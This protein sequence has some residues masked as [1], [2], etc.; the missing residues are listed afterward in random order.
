MGARGLRRLG[1]VVWGR[2]TGRG[3][4]RG[5]APGD[6]PFAQVRVEHAR[7][8]HFG[9]FR[10]VHKVGVEYAR[11]S[12]RLIAG[13]PPR[14]RRWA[15]PRALRIFITIGCPKAMRTGLAAVQPANLARL[16]PS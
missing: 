13:L 4:R 7:P 2:F 8:L 9:G 5:R 6:W 14:L 3:L 1:Y 16:G 12:G 15:A 11:L 10:Q